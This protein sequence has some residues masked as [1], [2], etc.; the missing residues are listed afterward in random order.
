MPQTD[1]L[2]ELCQKQSAV[3]ISTVDA[4]KCHISGPALKSA[5]TNEVTKFTVCTKDSHS[6]PTPVQQNVSAELK[7][8]VDGSVL[9]AIVVSQTSSMYEV[10]YTPSSRGCQEL[11]LQVDGTNIGI[12]QV[13]VQH[14]PT[15]LGIPVKVIDKVTP[16]YIAVGNKGELLVTEHW[17]IGRAHV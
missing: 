8:R 11:T 9:Q 4:T 3:Y 1:S 5:I 7:S 13:L 16:A 2:R 10:Y 14:P 17:E 12:F 15:Q 6:Q